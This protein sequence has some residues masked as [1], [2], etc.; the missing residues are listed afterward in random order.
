[1]LRR[2]AKALVAAVTGVVNVGS[3]WLL[4]AAANADTW[5]TVTVL[6]VANF[7]GTVAVAKVRNAGSR[8]EDFGRAVDR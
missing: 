1:M 2:Y 8:V 5:L 6:A 3:V 7:I 4:E